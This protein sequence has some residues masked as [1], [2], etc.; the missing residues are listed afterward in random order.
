MSG[1]F[2]PDTNKENKSEL[3]RACKA[4]DIKAVHLAI[5]NGAKDWCSGFLSAC[6]GGSLEIVNLMISKWNDR[7]S[8][9]SWDIGVYCAAIGGHLHIIQ[10]LISNTAS[11]LKKLTHSPDWNYILNGAC[12]GGNINVIQFVISQGANDWFVGFTGACRGGHM[13]AVQLMISKLQNNVNTDWKSI[14][15]TG[16]NYASFSGHMNVVE[17]MILKANGKCEW[18]LAFVEA[19]LG[20]HMELVQFLISKGACIWECGLRNAWTNGHTEIVSL[21]VSKGVGDLQRFYSWPA[22]N[23]EIYHLLYLGVDLDKFSKIIGYQELKSLASST[24]QSILKS[25]MMLPGLLDIV[26]KYIIL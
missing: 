7:S 16:L 1:L 12:E 9:Y 25:K 26:S 20:G 8:Y 24:K 3:D 21:M 11:Q 15:K 23:F 14:W 4:G 19:C 17:F 22:R 10:F 2:Y 18:N 5:S 13:P 6:Y